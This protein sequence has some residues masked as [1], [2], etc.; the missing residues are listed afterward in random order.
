MTSSD[1]LTKCNIKVS[2]EGQYTSTLLKSPT[3]VKT[4]GSLKLLRLQQLL[5]TCGVCKLYRHNI[6]DLRFG[7]END[8]VHTWSILDYWFSKTDQDSLQLWVF[9]CVSHKS[10]IKSN[11][12][13]S[14]IHTDTS[15][16]GGLWSFPY[17]KNGFNNL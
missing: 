15:I 1:S 11:Y 13:A 5:K 6:S 7:W 12:W 8:F 17:V 2:R 9:W 14:R 16:N 4:L 3:A 10:K